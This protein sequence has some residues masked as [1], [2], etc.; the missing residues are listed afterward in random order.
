MPVPRSLILIPE[1]QRR[2]MSRQ[3]QLTRAAWRTVRVIWQEFHTPIGVLLIALFAGGWLYGELWVQ[4]GHPRIPYVDL[5][6]T[7]LTLMIFAAPTE[8]PTEPQLVI[9]WYLMPVIGAYVAGH[10]IIDFVNLFFR[11]SEHHKSWEEAVASTYSDH[12]IVLGVGHLGTRV[13]RALRAMQ[14]EV[15]AIDQQASAEK[16]AEL[17]QLS[18]PLVEGDGRLPATLETAGIR[19]ARALIVCTSND[20]MNLEVTMRARDLNPDVRIVVRMWEDR[21]AE[22]IQRFMNVEAVLSATDLAAPAFASAALGI[23]ITQTL[24][25][26]GVEYSMIR[27]QVAPGSFLDGQ[28]VEA[29]QNTEDMDIVLHSHEGRVTVHPAP[30]T[31]VRAGDTVVIFAQHSKVTDV[32]ARNEQRR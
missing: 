11:A 23:E 29:L 6:Y 21:F 16:H 2:R 17:S 8:L 27:L 5:P 31:L 25:V 14:F 1:A 20:H 13:V 3:W 19:K 26:G 12:V 30:E 10:G 15:V 9:F 24:D 22:Q 32:V 28:T 7:M 4:A 18:V